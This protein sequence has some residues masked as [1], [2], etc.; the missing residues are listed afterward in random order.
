[1]R[2][3]N[4]FVFHSDEAEAL[5]TEAP[6]QKESAPGAARYT[7]AERPEPNLVRRANAAR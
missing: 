7:Q 3:A 2:G 1:M 4:Q 5:W 6:L